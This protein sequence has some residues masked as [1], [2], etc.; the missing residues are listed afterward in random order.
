MLERDNLIALPASLSSEMAK[1]KYTI[2]AGPSYET[3]AMRAFDFGV[4]IDLAQTDTNRESW[5]L[6][7][8]LVT[9]LRPHIPLL[10]VA[11]RYAG[12]A[13][14]KSPNVPSALIELGYLSNRK[15]ERNLKDPRFQKRIGRSL[16]QAIDKYFARKDQNNRS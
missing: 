13:V 4:L 6:A 16:L 10:K 5:H 1:N 3:E 11:H 8:D 9:E 12:F 2:P 7:R 15:D 14:L